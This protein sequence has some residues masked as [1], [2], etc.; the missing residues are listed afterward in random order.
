MGK[1]ELHQFCQLT[2]SA[3]SCVLQVTHGRT[4]DKQAGA[5]ILSGS[6]SVLRRQR[7]E[8]MEEAT[9]RKAKVLRQEM[10]KRGHAKIPRR[11]EE[12][13]QVR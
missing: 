8:A 6:K 5:A 1:Q 12:P 10:R 13:T 11:G 9:D 4:E 7:E 3:A 2:D